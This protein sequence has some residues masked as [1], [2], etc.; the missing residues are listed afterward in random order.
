MYN[1]DLL[2]LGLAL[3]SRANLHSY[4]GGGVARAK[5][6]EQLSAKLHDLYCE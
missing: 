3:F 6:K 1:G 2:L 4:V 5:T